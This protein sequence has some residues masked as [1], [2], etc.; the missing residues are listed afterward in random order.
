MP[1]SR[2]GDRIISRSAKYIWLAHSPDLNPLDYSVWGIF[3]NHVNHVNPTDKIELMNTVN[4]AAYELFTDQDLVKKIILNIRKRAKL[5]VEQKGC[6]FEHLLKLKNY[7][8][9]E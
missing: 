8:N 7:E 6:Y 4:E 3:E 1:V 9:E 2:L 5:C